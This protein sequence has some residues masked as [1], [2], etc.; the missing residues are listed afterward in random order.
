MMQ[1]T[2][3]DASGL[4]ENTWYPVTIAA[5][6]RMNIRV[7]VLVSLDSGTKPSWSTHERGF[8]LAK[9]G[10]LLRVFMALIVIAILLYTYQI[11]FMQI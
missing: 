2:E 11:S 1:R 10:N 5:G 6:E 4:D 8:L 3:I 7:E 9:F